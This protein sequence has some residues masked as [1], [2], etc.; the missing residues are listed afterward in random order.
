[1]TELLKEVTG[2][3]SEADNKK[4]LQELGLKGILDRKK[5]VV[6]LMDNL[7]FKVFCLGDGESISGFGHVV[8]IKGITFT[9]HED[10]YY[11][12][13]NDYSRSIDWWYYKL[14]IIL[15]YF[16]ADVKISG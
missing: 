13:S 16:W 5:L 6:F 3:L 8:K 4:L 9:H 12:I 15:C 1:M 10:Q 7:L 14:C 11:K 2:Y